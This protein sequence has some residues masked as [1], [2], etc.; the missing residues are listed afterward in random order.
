MRN[1]QDFM[2][3]LEKV[4]FETKSN[5]KIVI[6]DI[7]LDGSKSKLSVSK[8]KPSIRVLHYSNHSLIVNFNK[9][10]KDMK[11]GLNTCYVFTIIIVT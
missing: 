9:E 10:T 8:F 2:D 3:F 6:S 7:N 5:Y 11:L 4:L 1:S